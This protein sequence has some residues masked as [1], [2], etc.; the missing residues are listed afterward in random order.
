L[1]TELN[2]QGG[3]F[4]SNDDIT[5]QSPQSISVEGCDRE[6]ADTCLLGRPGEVYPMSSAHSHVLLTKITPLFTALRCCAFGNLADLY[7]DKM[8]IEKAS[9][10]DTNRPQLTA[11]LDYLRDGDVPRSAQHGS[12]CPKHTRSAKPDC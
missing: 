8:F 2:I 6:Y 12:A 10:K 4:D 11:A 3:H 7:I 9:G 5:L 1:A